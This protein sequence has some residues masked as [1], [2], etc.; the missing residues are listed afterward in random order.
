MNNAHHNDLASQTKKAWI[1]WSLLALAFI[2]VYFHRIALAVVMDYLMIDLRI[3]EAAVAG[4][5]AGMYS[6]IYLVM[7]IPSGILADFWGARKTVTAGLVVAGVGSFLFAVALG[8]PAAFLGRIVVGVGVSVIY[9]SILKTLS[10]WFRP[11]KFATMTGLTVLAGNLGGAMGTVPLAFLVEHFGWRNAFMA[12][13]VLTLLIALACWIV[14]RDAPGPVAGMN[15]IK[16][17]ASAPPG[18]RQPFLKTWRSL[19]VA[20]KK[21]VKN[22]QNWPPFISIFGVYG[23]LIAF[24]GAWSVNYLMQ[25]YGLSRGEAAQ[26]MLLVTVGMMAGCPLV[27]YISDKVRRRRAPHLVFFMAYMIIWGLFVVW[28]GKPPQSVLYP[29]FFFMGF[30]GSTI[31][32]IFAVVK[33]VN[34]PEYS[35]LALG[36]VNMGGFVGIALLQPLLGYLLDLRWQGELLLGARLYPLEAYRLMLASCLG[37][38]LVCFLFA[39]RIKETR[40]QNVHNMKE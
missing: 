16:N 37:V 14:V 8:A 17:G 29:L 32:T 27:G 7:Q 20:L 18:E 25:V 22:P 23:T 4:T 34:P 13:G 40:C 5:L 30:T 26:Y 31:I 39:L 12:V 24:S 38:L 11:D 9:V 33:E 21:V 1:I 6:I 35:G 3:D 15:P 2:I 28:G 36:V 10:V 19:A